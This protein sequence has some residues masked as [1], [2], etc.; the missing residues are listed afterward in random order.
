MPRRVNYLEDAVDDF[1]KKKKK[2]SNNI[3]YGEII[4]QINKGVPKRNMGKL[5]LTRIKKP[6][7][8][9]KKL[10]QQ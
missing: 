7:K 6:S 1:A 4:K 8:P 3:D 5:D 10:M 2:A 9:R